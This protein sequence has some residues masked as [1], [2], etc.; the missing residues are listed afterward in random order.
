MALGRGEET[1]SLAI[2][3]LI[4]EYHAEQEKDIDKQAGQPLWKPRGS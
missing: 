1:G 2:A 3:S 4:G